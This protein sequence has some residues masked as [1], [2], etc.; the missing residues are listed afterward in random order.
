MLLNR[1]D[2]VASIA[3]EVERVLI[4]ALHKIPNLSGGERRPLTEPLNQ[5]SPLA[6]RQFGLQWPPRLGEEDRH[7]GAGNA[8]SSMAQ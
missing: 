8:V 7:R 4:R 1:R 5:F 6:Q 3:Q 2:S